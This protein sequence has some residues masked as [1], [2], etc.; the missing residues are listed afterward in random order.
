MELRGLA[1][2]SSAV[3]SDE[4]APMGVFPQMYGRNGP[5]A[6]E[7]VDRSHGEVNRA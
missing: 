1:P 3:L 5:R 4:P 6:V 2:A 7:S